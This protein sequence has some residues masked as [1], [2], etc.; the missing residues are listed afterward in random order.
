MLWCQRLTQA[1]NVSSRNRSSCLQ[2]SSHWCALQ[3]TVC[4][5]SNSQCYDLDK[6]P[7]ELQLRQPRKISADSRDVNCRISRAYV[8]W[9]LNPAIL[10]QCQI[11]INSRKLEL[12]LQ[13]GVV[14]NNSTWSIFF[15]YWSWTNE[16]FLNKVFSKERQ[17]W[18][19]CLGG[20]SH[21]LLLV[22]V[23]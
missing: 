4:V 21:I 3:W 12:H 17:T 20:A 10:Y 22:E 13:N 2:V 6:T 19:Q 7:L 18:G 9:L 8:C 23:P 16:S 14:R 11:S 15:T 5:R 1:P